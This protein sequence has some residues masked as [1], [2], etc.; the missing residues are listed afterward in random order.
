MDEFKEKM[1]ESLKDFKKKAE[2]RQEYNIK[3]LN[4]LRDMILSYPELRFGQILAILKLDGDIFNEE[5]VDT[6]ERI[7]E[8]L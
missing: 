8:K 3:C 4:L 7:K 5:S 1:E 2:K 6:Y